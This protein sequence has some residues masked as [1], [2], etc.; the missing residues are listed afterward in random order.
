MSGACIFRS[1]V[2][3]FIIGFVAF[4]ILAGLNLYVPAKHRQILDKPR[5]YDLLGYPARVID[6]RI[7][8]NWA[9]TSIVVALTTVVTFGIKYYKEMVQAFFD[10]WWMG[11]IIVILCLIVIYALFGTVLIIAAALGEVIKEDLLEKHYARMYGRYIAR[12]E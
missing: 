3:V 4:L 8:L 10:G 6:Q 2:F 11:H 5:C 12:K 7:S 9:G 1:W